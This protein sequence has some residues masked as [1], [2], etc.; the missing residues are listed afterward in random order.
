[1]GSQTAG[2]DYTV[3]LDTTWPLQLRW[4]L[5]LLAALALAAYLPCF[6]IPLIADD[7]PNI[8]QSL[9]YGAPSGL[10]TLLQDAQFRLRSTSYWIWY[11]VWSSAGM[12]PAA[13]HAVSVGLHV[14]NTWLVLAIC[15]SWQPMRAAAFWAAAFFAIHEGHQEAVMWYSAISEL[16]MFA[17]GAGALW[18]WLRSGK[19]RHRWPMAVAAWAL[20]ALALLSKESAVIWVPLFA[21]PLLTL[22]SEPGQWKRG[23]PSLI[24]FAILAVLA[25]ISLT[26]RS[27]NFRLN[28]G[29]FSLHAPFWLT[30]PHSMARLMWIWGW[31][32]LVA[33]VP[34]DAR[35]KRAAGLAL[36]WMG[37]AFL[38]YIFLTYSTAIPSRQTYLASAG[39]AMLVGLAIS[40]Y[41]D[42]RRAVAA[43]FAVMV[44]HNVAVLWTKKRGQFL[45]RAAPTSEL[46]SLARGTTQAIWVQCFPLPPIDAQEAVRMAARRSPADLLWDARAAEARSAVRFCYTAKSR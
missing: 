15:L 31:P 16:L 12:N 13:C 5:A 37:V 8:A 44:L 43:L 22:F 9:T 23:L 10:D 3:G 25:A 34:G 20:F 36:V 2:K 42:R 14:V 28:D 33:V 6:G 32:A 7:Y 26:A 40:Q 41:A 4:Q 39:L 19:S 38:P 29:S 1:V 46:I 30:W 17:F 21:L 27:D 11:A 35:L 45:E 24:P 18:C